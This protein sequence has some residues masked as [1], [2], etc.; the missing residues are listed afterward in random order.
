MCAACEPQGPP[1][2]LVH[3]PT[4]RL[5]DI[6][7]SEQKIK[8]ARQLIAKK[9]HG[10]VGRLCLVILDVLMLVCDDDP[11]AAFGKL[12]GFR[13]E[14]QRTV[15]NP[16]NQGYAQAQWFRRLDSKMRFCLY[17]RPVHG[18]LAQ[19]KVVLYADDR[20]GLLPSEVFGVLEVMPITRMLML[21]L[22][23]DFSIATGVNSDFVL[24][25]TLFGKSQRDLSMQNAWG[26]WWGTRKSGK[27]VK[28]YF[29]HQVWGQRVEFRMRRKFL[30]L[31]GIR[32][33]FDFWKFRALLPERH[34]LFAT[35]DEQKLIVQLRRTRRAVETLRILRELNARDRDLTAQMNF[36]RRDVRLKNTRRLLIPHPLNRVVQR[37]LGEFTA[38]WPTAP[39]HLVITKTSSANGGKKGAKN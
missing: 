11:R 27:R 9:F 39:K 24:G 29:K 19:Y 35:I 22:A 23:F 21:E 26:D 8:K 34:F 33:V 10:G 36:L 3:E 28:S 18:Y 6:S 14:R 16:E 15:P 2:A 4:R 31:H 20:T 17:S 12:L 32:D 37:A 13:A 5:A 7:V 38:M 1:A 30:A 25:W